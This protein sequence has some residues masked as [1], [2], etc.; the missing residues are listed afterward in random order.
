MQ[1]CPS[2]ARIAAKWVRQGNPTTAAMLIL[3]GPSRLQPPLWRQV[4]AAGIWMLLYQRPLTRSGVL[5]SEPGPIPAH[6]T[7]VTVWRKLIISIA[8]GCGNV[9]IPFAFLTVR[10][11]MSTSQR[12]ESKLVFKARSDAHSYGC[13]TRVWYRSKGLEHS[14]FDYSSRLEVS[15]SN[16]EMCLSPD[17]CSWKTSAPVSGLDTKELRKVEQTRSGFAGYLFSLRSL[18]QNIWLTPACTHV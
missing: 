16:Q 5:P 18:W 17:H 13:L 10:T 7:S 3:Q 2:V 12:H 1:S 6:K 15:N 14:E 11:N 4:W 9:T 8:L